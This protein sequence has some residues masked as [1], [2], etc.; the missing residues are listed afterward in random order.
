MLR[1]GLINTPICLAVL[2]GACQRG[3]EDPAIT[4]TGRKARISGDWTVVAF[5]TQFPGEK[6]TGIGEEATYIVNDTTQFS[7]TFQWSFSFS[8]NGEYVSVRTES[9]PADTTVGREAYN[10]VTESKG[11]W[12]FTGGNNTPSKSQLLLVEKVVQITESDRGS[13]IQIVSVDSPSIGR[14]YEIIGLSSKKMKLSFES[15]VYEAFGQRLESVLLEMESR[16]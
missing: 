12:E 16:K 6:V 8:R 7:V 4:L 13:N 10:R 11:I 3:P 5:Q 14:V 1:W 2:L 15:I 9:Y